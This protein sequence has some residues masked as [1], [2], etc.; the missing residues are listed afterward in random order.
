MGIPATLVTNT[1]EELTSS[2][3]FCTV[4]GWSNGSSRRRIYLQRILVIALE[5]YGK[6]FTILFRL[7]FLI[8]PCQHYARRLHIY[9]RD[10]FAYVALEYG[11]QWAVAFH[12]MNNFL[13][14]VVVDIYLAQMVN[15]WQFSLCST[16][17]FNWLCRISISGYF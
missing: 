14:A 17:R 6:V 13:F 7:F 3:I 15:F 2:I 4:F 9:G 8:I 11:F 12:M 1:S 10:C 5:R 16:T